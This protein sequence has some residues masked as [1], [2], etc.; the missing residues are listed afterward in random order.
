MI[1]AS[2][3]QL[4]AF[5]GKAAVGWLGPGLTETLETPDLLAEAGIQYVGDWVLD[6]EP[7]EI[8][9]QHGPLVTLPYTV[10]L[11]DIPMMMVQHHS[12]QEFVTRCL[13]YFDRIHQE[14]AERAK[15]MA[16]AVHPYIS[17]T[18]FRIKYF[19]AVLE[20]IKARPGVVFWTGEQILAWYRGLRPRR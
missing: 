9:T 5:T 1:R 11:N 3:D 8:R 10:E 7:C 20:A 6:D 15:V 13:D 17:G 2:L 18:P 12:A 4:R 19:E 16:I 14:S